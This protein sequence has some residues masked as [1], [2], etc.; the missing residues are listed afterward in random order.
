MSETE[1]RC[2]ICN[3][4]MDDYGCIDFISH[5][6]KLVAS[7]ERELSTLRAENEAYKEML[8]KAY[9][10]EIALER[11]ESDGEFKLV[12]RRM[13]GSDVWAVWK[14]SGERKD[15]FL[16]ALAAFRSIQEE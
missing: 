8:S 2:E 6:A 4:E 11:Y 7:L 10:I 12:R 15:G 5:G 1:K 9:L 14:P 16:S 3:G 13:M